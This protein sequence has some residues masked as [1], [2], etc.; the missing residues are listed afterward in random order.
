MCKEYNGHWEPCCQQGP[1]GPSGAQ[2][3]Q[4]IQGVSGAQGSVGNTGMQGQQGLQGLTG[5]MGPAGSSG[6]AIGYYMNVYSNQAQSIAAYLGNSDT[7]ILQ[8]AN[9]VDASAFDVSLAPST[10]SMKFLKHGIFSIGWVLQ[11]KVTPPVPN[12]VPSWS[13]G[14]WLDGV[15]VPG[16]IESGYTQAPGDD[17]QHCSGQVIIEVKAG[18]VIMLRNTSVSAVS[19]DPNVTGAVFP[20]TT[21]SVCATLVKVLP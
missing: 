18:S 2:G 15:L 20:I 9:A 1:Q 19:L 11:A 3:A 6:T 21:A 10:G 13:F 16:S 4:G 7:V 17:D 5:P 14:L 12:P 8:S